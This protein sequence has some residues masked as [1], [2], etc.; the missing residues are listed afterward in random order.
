[1]DSFIGHVSLWN[2]KTELKGIRDEKQLYAAFIDFG[3]AIEK[4]DKVPR[5][6]FFKTFYNSKEN[7][8]VLS[9]VTNGEIDNFLLFEVKKLQNLE[10]YLFFSP[11]SFN[12]DDLLALK[13]YI[14]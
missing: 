3:F 11:K 6:R 4:G 7:T 2:P 9:S 8:V 1:M 12:Q 5:V 13:D 10:K 14:S